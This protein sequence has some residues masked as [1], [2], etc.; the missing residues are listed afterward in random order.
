MKKKK[1][2][3]N[4]WVMGKDFQFKQFT[5]SQDRCAMKVGTDGVLLGAWAHVG[6]RILDIGTGTGIIALMMAQRFPEA[7]VDAI[8][9]DPDAAQQA[10]ENVAR[11]P[12]AERIH[13]IETSLQ[14][15]EPDTHCST[16]HY[17]IIVTNPPFFSHS[18][19]SPDGSR[20]LARQTDSLPFSAIFAFATEHLTPDG[21]LSAIIPTDYLEEFSQE[22]FMRGMFL[23]RQYAV[24]TVER[25]PAKRTLVA[26]SPS[27]PAVFD[28]QEV[29]LMDKSGE[30]S[31][32][33][34]ELTKEF[35]I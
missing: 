3:R 21:E 9:I 26:F 16:T 13:V 18:L 33:Y 23:S 32:W 22:A 17:N 30:R 29:V 31:E 24:K 20:R 35:Y 12:F 25:K 19:K 2:G 4:N 6:A 14:Q 8:E 7:T 10:S 34:R 28:K 1:Q 11:S 27:R 15:F 5:V